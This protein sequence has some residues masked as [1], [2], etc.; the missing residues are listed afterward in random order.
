[1]L[2]FF[3]IK[4]FQKV[5]V[6]SGCWCD[7]SKNHRTASVST[8]YVPLAWMMAPPFQIC[9]SQSKMIYLLMLPQSWSDFLENVGYSRSFLHGPTLTQ[10]WF[11]SV[12]PCTYKLSSLKTIQMIATSLGINLKNSVP[13]LTTSSCV[14]LN[15]FIMYATLG[16]SEEWATNSWL[17]QS[18]CIYF[19]RPFMH[20]E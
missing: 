14:G 11:Y 10:S 17:M 13:G 1:M 18:C 19:A 7:F 16:T 3:R 5:R 20:L 15:M 6:P 12:S 8:M 4:C 9:W 2:H